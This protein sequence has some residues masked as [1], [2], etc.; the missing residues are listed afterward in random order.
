MTAAAGIIQRMRRLVAEADH[1]V[2]DRLRPAVAILRTGRVAARGLVK[3]RAPQMAAALAYRTVFSLIPVLVLGLVVLGSFYGPTAIERPLDKMLTYFGLSDMAMQPAPEGVAPE[4]AEGLDPAAGSAQ[5]QT[6]RTAADWI[7]SLVDRVRGINFAAIGVVGLILLMY[8]AFSLLIEIERAFNI[9]YN[10]PANRRLLT[11]IVNYWAV[12]TLGPLG[13]IAS[14]Y[15]A[16]RLNAAFTGAGGVTAEILGQVLM[17]LVSWLVLLLAYSLLP[18]TRVHKRPAAIGA[19]VGALLWEVSKW[20][21]GVYLSFATGNSVFY[22]SLGLIPVFLLWVYITWLCVIFGLEMAFALQTVATGADVTQAEKRTAG[23]I[24][25]A[26]ALVSIMRAAGARFAKG[27]VSDQADLATEAGVAETAAA[28][29]V[30][31]LVTRGLL[32]RVESPRDEDEAAADEDRAALT[33]GRPPEAIAVADILHLAHE[34]TG[35]VGAGDE[36]AVL[37]R[38]RQ[39]QIDAV[40]NMTL[41]DV[42]RED[43]TKTR[44]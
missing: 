18:N 35:G 41:A 38:L 7:E 5:D 9:V 23:E 2:P 17:F 31:L 28:R 33:L 26:A 8:A 20:G 25:E 36:H 44:S 14:F 27:E 43:A 11:R 4:G 19:F 34:I 29:M 22:G 16:E 42:L 40:R 6:M 3:D 15:A 39:A 10:A 21:F 13:L 12:L 32:R 37:Q 24:V 30:D 1:S